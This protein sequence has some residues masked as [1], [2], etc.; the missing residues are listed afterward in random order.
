MCMYA[1][2]LCLFVCMYVHTMYSV[3]EKQSNE[4]EQSDILSFMD[5]TAIKDADAQYRRIIHY[6]KQRGH[7]SHSMYVLVLY[8]YS[9]RSV[10]FMNMY[11]CM[12][13]FEEGVRPLGSS[14]A[15]LE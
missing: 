6:L 3:T 14:R 11:V 5:F 12:Y 7:E 2:M 9:C 8:N 13:Q 15:G 10:C 1:C 4:S